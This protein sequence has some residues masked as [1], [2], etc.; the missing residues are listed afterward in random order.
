LPLNIL[1]VAHAAPNH[2]LDQETIADTVLPLSAST[3]EQ[4]RKLALIYKKTRIKSRGSV[5][6]DEADGLPNYDFYYLP[7]GPTD[8]GPGTDARMKAYQKHAGPLALRAASE[9]LERSGLQPGEITHLINVTCTGFFAPGNDCGLVEGLSLK[10]TVER[11]QIGFMG[12]H[13]LQN[14]L[15]QASAIA[16]ADESARILITSVELCSLHFQYGWNTEQV[17][18]NSLFA[19]GAGALVVGSHEQDGSW[20]MTAGG[21]CLLPDSADAMTWRI[22]DH[23]FRMT[24][25]LEIPALIETHLAAYLDGWLSDKGLIRD[26]IATWA[27]HPGGPRVLEAAEKALGLT[28]DETAVSREVLANHGNMSSATM[29]FILRKLMDSGAPLPCVA[30]G[31][32]PGVTVEATLFE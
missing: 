27:I 22:G 7:S 2:S 24:L 16:G 32:G 11:L 12:C 19:D 30:L 25:S 28:R 26:D 6:L 3:T 29:A 21:S 18:S 31:F 20:A 17:V 5:L 13:A 23:G 9:A 15:H 14:A 8:L 1:A 4:K 10:P